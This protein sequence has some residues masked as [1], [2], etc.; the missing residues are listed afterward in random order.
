[1]K[2]YLVKF[3]NQWD[4]EGTVVE[5]VTTEEGLNNMEHDSNVAIL[6]YEPEDPPEWFKKMHENKDKDI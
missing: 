1:M 2:F 6:S 4:E 5:Q 3:V